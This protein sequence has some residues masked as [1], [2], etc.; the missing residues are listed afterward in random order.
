M[1]SQLN[2]DDYLQ[3][4]RKQVCSRCP[5]RPPG[6]PP[7]L[8][9]GKCCGIELHTEAL[10]AVVQANPCVRIDPYIDGFHSSFCRTCLVNPTSQCPCPLDYLITLAVEAIESVD[11]PT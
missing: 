9:L 10:V 1:A 3:L 6:G 2:T 4:L 8:P 7:C 11:E 5:D